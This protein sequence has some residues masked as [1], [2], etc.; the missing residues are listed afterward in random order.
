MLNENALKMVGPTFEEVGAKTKA[1]VSPDS[2]SA[3][4]ATLTLA[5]SPIVAASIY[6]TTHKGK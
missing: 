5:Y 1:N 4:I 3:A 2:L 6:A